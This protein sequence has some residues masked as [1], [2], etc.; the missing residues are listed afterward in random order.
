MEVVVLVARA[1]VKSSLA[2]V[3]VEREKD[4]PRPM[5]DERTKHTKIEIGNSGEEAKKR[6]EINH[7][8][9]NKE[10]ERESFREGE[11]ALP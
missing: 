9:W 1:V 2:E 10:R 5:A 11:R 6:E 7:D 3:A 8:L 4:S